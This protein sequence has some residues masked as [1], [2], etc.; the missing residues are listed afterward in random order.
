M[1]HTTNKNDISNYISI[2][3]TAYPL[4]SKVD[5]SLNTVNNALSNKQNIFTC[6]TPLIK[7][8]IF[9]IKYQ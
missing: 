3:L 2:D 6:I 9:Q 7:N 1:Y 5:I 4:K 8:D